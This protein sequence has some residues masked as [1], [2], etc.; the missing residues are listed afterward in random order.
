MYGDAVSL[1]YEDAGARAVSPLVEPPEVELDSYCVFVCFSGSGEQA[2]IGLAD[3]RVV[4][5]YVQGDLDN[6][7]SIEL[8]CVPLCA[9]PDID[10]DGVSLGTDDGRLLR[11]CSDGVVTLHSAQSGWIEQV[12]VHNV[13]GF[14][15]FSRGR[16]VGLIDRRGQCTTMLVDHPSTPTGIAFSP[17][18]S[19]L[20]VSHYDGVSVWD[21]DTG[22]KSAV[23][24][25]HG[26][27]TAVTWSPDGR[28]IVTAMQDNELHAW[29]MPE[30]KS[31]KMSGYPAKIRSLSW[32]RDGAYLACSGADTVTS[33]CFEGDG[34][35]GS[36]PSEF[37]YVFS[38][39][40]SQVAAHPHDQIVAAGY[41]NGTVLVGSIATGDALIA[42]P[43]GGG[44]VT[45]LAWAPTGE[46]LLA[47]TE[48]G[49][50]SMMRF[51][52]FA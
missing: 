25:W 51:K 35:M 52:G 20:A 31:L 34:P 4:H 10:E 48:S 13:R 1:A 37:G 9:A 11:V 19:Q 43:A 2:F 32:T 40:V 29:R 15:A 22:A 7:T 14:R 38:S 26:S 33:W 12:A 36:A 24:Q 47:A 42:R 28:F 39:T 44:R 5:A 27:H 6:S 3:R 45:A 46:T 17:S 41:D 50:F 49:L 23:L 8:K 16:T 30:A 18:G 21:L